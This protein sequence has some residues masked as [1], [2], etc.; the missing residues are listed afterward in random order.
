MF[1][2]LGLLTRFVDLLASRPR[3][4]LA[5]V[6][7]AAELPAVE[8]DFNETTHFGKLL[9]PSQAGVENQL[10]VRLGHI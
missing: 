2:L 6:L 7:A 1:G 10:F 4:V 5:A 8:E 3:A 9:T